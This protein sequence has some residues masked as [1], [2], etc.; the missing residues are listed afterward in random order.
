MPQYFIL[1]VIFS[2]DVAFQKNENVLIVTLNYAYK[3]HVTILFKVYLNY[4]ILANVF[5]LT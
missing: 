4:S 5:C 2:R 3:N 1:R